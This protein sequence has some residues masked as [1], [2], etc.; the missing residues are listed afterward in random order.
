MLGARLSGLREADRVLNRIEDLERNAKDLRNISQE[1]SNAQKTMQNKARFLN[2][3]SPVSPIAST[4]SNQLS[5]ALCTT[6]IPQLEMKH[7]R[8]GTYS[9]PD[10]KNS[11]GSMTHQKPQILLIPYSRASTVSNSQKVHLPRPSLV[12]AKITDLPEWKLLFEKLSIQKSYWDLF[13]KPVALNLILQVKIVI[14]FLKTCSQAWNV[15]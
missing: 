2:N 9:Q 8:D 3:L 4:P 5:G 15:S 7:V 6:P 13:K 12:R 1:S 10:Q 11:K 14:S